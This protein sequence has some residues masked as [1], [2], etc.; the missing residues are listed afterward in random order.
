MSLNPREKEKLQ[1]RVKELRRERSE[2]LSKK[3]TSEMLVRFPDLISLSTISVPGLVNKHLQIGTC[4]RKV[5]GPVSW[6][7]RNIGAIAEREE[8]SIRVPFDPFH[9]P[10]CFA[11]SVGTTR[12]PLYNKGYIYGCT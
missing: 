11:N 3:S 12:V 1:N 2:E 6:P 7:G 4:T 10:Q 8:A 5:S 9:T